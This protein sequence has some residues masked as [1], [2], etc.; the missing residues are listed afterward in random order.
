ML[1]AL[2]HNSTSET[3]ALKLGCGVG[4]DNFTGT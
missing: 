3:T 2:G 1:L 4:V